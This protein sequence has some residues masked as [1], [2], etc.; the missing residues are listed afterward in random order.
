MDGTG[1]NCLAIDSA[2]AGRMILIANGR[3]EK[4]VLCENADEARAG[5]FGEL[6]RARRGGG[7]LS[8][9]ALSQGD[10]ARQNLVGGGLVSGLCAGALSHARE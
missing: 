4:M 10:T 5:G 8:C 3:R 2:N 9:I 7:F 1:E 6:T